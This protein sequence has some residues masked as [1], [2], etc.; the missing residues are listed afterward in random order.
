[1]T[2]LKDYQHF[3]GRHWETGSLCNFYAYRG[4]VAAHTGKSYSEALFLGISGGIAMGYFQFAYQGYDPHVA[5]LTRNTFNPLDTL[6]ERLGVEQE[7]LQT[8]LPQ[9]GLRNL[10]STLENGLPALTWVDIFSLPYFELPNDDDMYQMYPVVVY[11]YDE[12]Q[13]TVWI[14]DRA[15][16][17]LQVTT[18]Q[19]AAARA[20]VKKDKFRV[21]VPGDLDPGRLASA[22]H[23]GIWDT[24]RLYSEAPPKGSPKNFGFEAY[25]HW[26][27][28]LEKTNLRNSWANV[29]PPGR[30]MI[31]GL[32]SAF[33]ATIQNGEG[34]GAE[35][36]AYADFLEEAALILRRP[37]LVGCAEHFREAAAA[38]KELGL[39][40]L[41]DAIEPFGVIRRQMLRRRELFLAQGGA[42]R[43]EIDQLNREIARLKAETAADF[44]LEGGELAQFFGNLREKITGVHDVEQVAVKS[45]QAAL[46]E[47]G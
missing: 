4:L 9:H 40:L 7:L 30:P 11:G 47:Q 14:A 45:L 25:R 38:W 5:I 36:A 2:K 33:Y 1:M 6:L 42:A 20:R 10:L 3:H 35:R 43:E 8:S 17:P 46:V 18:A 31:A 12:A 19:L 41:P 23:K 37:A 16:V 24:L 32:T 44:P 22:V 27:E 26:C 21:L 15:R 34:D 13:D 29:F 28:T 39:A